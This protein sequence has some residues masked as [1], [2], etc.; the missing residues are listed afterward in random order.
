[1]ILKL[2]IFFF[3]VWW[4]TAKK[5]FMA[6]Y[7]WELDFCFLNV[8]CNFKEKQIHIFESVFPF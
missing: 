4:K 5:Y 3:V 6:S 1:M 7:K 8:K 2:K